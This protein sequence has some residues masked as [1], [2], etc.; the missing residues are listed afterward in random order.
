MTIILELPPDT[1]AR[2]RERSQ[3]A[4][5][6]PEAVALA[7][8]R[9]GLDTDVPAAPRLSKEALLAEFDAWIGSLK[10]GNP[11]MDDSRESIYPDRT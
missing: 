11:N 9:E 8:L 5:V 1:E 10:P 6:P 2:L 3:L 4:G 7:A